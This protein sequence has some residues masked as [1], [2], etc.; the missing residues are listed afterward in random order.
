MTETSKRQH[1]FAV[2]AY[3][4]SPYLEECILS[5]RHQTAASEI[6]IS[7]STPSEFIYRIARLYSLPVFLSHGGG[8]G[9]DWNAALSHAQT[10]YVTIAH[11]DDVYLK[12]YTEIILN[13]F[14]R[15]PRG[16]IAFTD[17]RE[18]YNGKVISENLN[19]KIK[20]L[21]LLPLRADGNSRFS[22][23]AAI[24]FGNAICC[25][26]VAY[27]T[28]MIGD[29]QFG[30]DMR[31]NI[32]W[33]AWETLSKKNGSF[34][35][36]PEPAVLHRIHS[37]SETSNMIGGNLRHDEDL[38]IFRRFWPRPLAG[39]ISSFYKNSEKGNIK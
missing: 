1:S 2:C 18:I 30:Q 25:P 35:Y 26:A 14:D 9:S 4:D 15:D 22:K 20:E 37:E 31:S 12:N 6:F 5:L 36:C 24:A 21:M 11:Q 27:N 32:D 23:R 29:F 38:E 34:L 19:L 10:P 13:A 39:L 17:Y 7:T 3:G 33:A 28:G 8:I 16:M